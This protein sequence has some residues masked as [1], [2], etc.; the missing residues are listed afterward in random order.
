MYKLFERTTTGPIPG[1]HAFDRAHRQYNQQVIKMWKAWIS[2]N[3]I[4]PSRMTV[5]QAKQFIQMV[6]RLKHPAIRTFLQCINQKIGGQVIKKGGNRL[7]K[8][9]G[10]RLL[11]KVGKKVVAG[12][13]RKIPVVT[14]AYFFYDW[15]AGGLVY[16]GNELT[17][18]VSEAWREDGIF[19][20]NDD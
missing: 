17:W 18:P 1:G 5:T 12:V 16:A 10:K 9:G 15:Y 14:V 11:K 8:Q 4:Q 20:D 19:S 3:E 13:L 6:K 7:L 2:K